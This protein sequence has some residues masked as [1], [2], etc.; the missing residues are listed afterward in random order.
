MREKRKNA[1]TEKKIKIRSRNGNGPGYTQ[2][3]GSASARLFRHSITGG[4][5][6]DEIWILNNPIRCVVMRVPAGSATG[7]DDR[8]D[9]G[10]DQPAAPGDGNQL[11]APKGE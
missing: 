10:A 6:S 4:V 3:T 9:R 5:R 11:P 2:R 7:A 1:N 8:G